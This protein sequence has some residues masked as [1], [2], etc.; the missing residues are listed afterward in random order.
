M[1][2]TK[3]KLLI[4]NCP[5]YRHDIFVSAGAT[6]E[7]AMAY[8]KKEM[9]NEVFMEFLEGSKQYFEEVMGTKKAFSIRSNKGDLILLLPAPVDEW[10]YYETI[11]HELSHLMDWLVEQKMLQ[12]ESEARAYLTE[13]LFVALRV[14]LVG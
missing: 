2:K 1:K 3:H 4:Q 14:Q 5:P 9:A 6:Y 7:Q 11:V 13:W 10:W 12:G 8:A